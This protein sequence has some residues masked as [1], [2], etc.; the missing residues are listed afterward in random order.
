MILSIWEDVSR[1]YANN[2]AISYKVLQH[3]QILVSTG[4]LESILLQIPRL[5]Y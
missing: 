5:L 1:L 4:V 3:L 2:Y